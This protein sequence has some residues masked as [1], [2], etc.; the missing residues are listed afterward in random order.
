MIEADS[1]VLTTVFLGF[2]GHFPYFLPYHLFCFSNLL[3]PHPNNLVYHCTFISRGSAKSGCHTGARH[4]II[5]SVTHPMLSAVNVFLD[6][7]LWRTSSA[8]IVML[9]GESMQWNY[10][11]ASKASGVKSMGE[12][13]LCCTSFHSHHNSAVSAQASKQSTS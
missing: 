1:C 4:R 3:F 10:E 11:V 9:R 13:V 2:V 7:L 5:F 8:E 12:R 6:V